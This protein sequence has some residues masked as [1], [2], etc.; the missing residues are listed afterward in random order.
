PNSSVKNGSI[1]SR[2]RGS[3]GVVAWQSRYTGRV[4]RGAPE[5]S[6]RSTGVRLMR[7]ALYALRSSRTNRPGSESPVGREADG[8]QREPRAVRLN[9][10]AEDIVANL[11]RRPRHF[12]GTD[13]V[14][15]DAE[16][17]LIDERQPV[18]QRNDLEQRELAVD[19]L[20]EDRRDV[21]VALRCVE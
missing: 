13:V 15:T 10:R 21:H 2:T 19:R 18:D 17:S 8:A 20:V 3:T 5:E 14:V 1:A 11:V 6:R 4:P 16:L 9:G 12:P 7:R